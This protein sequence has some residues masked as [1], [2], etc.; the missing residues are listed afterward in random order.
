M[1]RFLKFLSQTYVY[2]LRLD[3]ARNSS[4]KKFVCL[5]AVTDTPLTPSRTKERIWVVRSNKPAL[6]HPSFFLSRVAKTKLI[7]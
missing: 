6:K 3:F 5:F 1:S 7:A 4:N 2:H